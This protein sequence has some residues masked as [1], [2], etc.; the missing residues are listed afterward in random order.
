M[1][2]TIRVKFLAMTEE[3][4]SN[5]LVFGMGFGTGLGTLTGVRDYLSRP[6]ND[7]E[8]VVIPF[9][10]LPFLGCWLGGTICATYP[11]SPFLLA[12]GGA[13]MAYKQWNRREMQ[14]WINCKMSG[15]NP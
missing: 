9:T 4:L 3:A 10:T 1:M 12:T 7:F 11:V 5:R 14:K 15:T 2:S 8:D 6:D 13:A